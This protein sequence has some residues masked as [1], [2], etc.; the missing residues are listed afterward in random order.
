MKKRKLQSWSFKEAKLS[1][2]EEMRSF[3]PLPQ[4]CA[5]LTS[6]GQKTAAPGSYALV[7]PHRA[8]A[9]SYSFD[10]FHTVAIINVTE[11]I[12]KEVSESM[13]TSELYSFEK[14]HGGL[15]GIWK[16]YF[17]ILYAA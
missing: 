14:E 5:H 1:R 8:S 3:L 15:V 9:L 17:E 6:E 11:D 7:S 13:M 4:P 2:L 10:Q 16:F 12:T